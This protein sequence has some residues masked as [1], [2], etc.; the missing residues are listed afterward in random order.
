MVKGFLAKGSEIMQLKF[1]KRRMV[2]LEIE[3]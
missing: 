3:I 2:P 1:L